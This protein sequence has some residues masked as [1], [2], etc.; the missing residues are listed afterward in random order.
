MNMI[1]FSTSDIKQNSLG[2]PNIIEESQTLHNK[3]SVMTGQCLKT[4]TLNH[5]GLISAIAKE[6]KIVEKIDQRISIQHREENITRGQSVLAMILNGLGFTERRLYMVSSF[7]KHKPVE[8]LIGEGV[9][10]EKLNDDN[11]GRTLDAIYDYGPTKLYTEVAFE[12]GL[13]NNALGK[14][15]HLDTTS[16]SVEGEYEDTPFDKEHDSNFNIT[17]G[18]SKDHRPDL[19]QFIISLTTTGPSSIPIWMESLSGNTSDK[20]SFIDTIN[21]AKKFQDEIREH[22]QFIW[23]ADSALYSKNRLLKSGDFVK[24]ITRIPENIKEAKD[25]VTRKF[26]DFKWTP[27]DIGYSYIRYTTNHGGVKQRWILIFSE[28]AYKKETANLKDNFER[29]ESNLNKKIKKLE[30]ELFACKRDAKKDFLKFQKT[31]KLFSLKHE[32]IKVYGKKDGKKGRPKNGD[33]TIKGYNLK[34]NYFWNKEEVSKLENSKGRFILGSNEMSENLISD[35][36]IFREYKEQSKT[37]RTFRYLKDPSFYASEVFLKK[38]ERIQSLM[39]VMA[40]CLLIYN[41]GEYHLRKLLKD[42]NDTLPNQNGR[43]T[44]RPTLKMIFQ[45]FRDVSI[46]KVI[47]NSG[48]LITESVCNLDKIHHKI[49]QYFGKIAADIYNIDYTGPPDKSS[50]FF[51]LK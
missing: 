47:S 10:S 21:A 33:K 28:K 19:N 4:E 22:Q 1:P 5:L 17:N 24:W 46:A 43:P 11:L 7:F 25:L 51:L 41:V 39:V 6:L 23:V 36:E 27:L 38:P 31:C 37:E 13:E 32:V 16:L 49:I 26:N 40:L 2:L 34:I 48:E 20:K 45:F 12:V 15:S 14:S 30:G 8:K 35:E 29:K 9:T 44:K 18:H 3:K 50:P 42:N